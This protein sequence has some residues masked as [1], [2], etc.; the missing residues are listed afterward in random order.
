V[1]LIDDLVRAVIFDLEAS[2]VHGGKIPV[3]EHTGW[4]RLALAR[5][6]LVEGLHARDEYIIAEA[7][8]AKPR[9]HAA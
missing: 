3:G 5:T 4:Q 2:R 9:D 7:R 1:H 6:Q 8:R